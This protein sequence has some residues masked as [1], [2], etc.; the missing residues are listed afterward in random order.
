LETR[1]LKDIKDELQHIEKKELIEICLQ[2]I[3]F[4]KHNKEL[5][6]FVL[7]GQQNLNTYINE[8]KASVDE[9]FTEVNATNAYF[10]K[11]TLRKIA[12]VANTYCAYTK[13]PIALVEVS[14]HFCTVMQNNFRHLLNNTVIENIYFGQYKKAMKALGSMHEDEQY[15]YLKLA[16]KLSK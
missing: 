1:T 8:I 14:F 7:F 3:K 11:K 16:E 9:L 12:R 6:H 2:L 13:Q 4:K 10:A 15:D 5:L